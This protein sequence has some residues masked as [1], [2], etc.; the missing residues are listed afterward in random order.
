MGKFHL[1]KWYLDCT[2]DD[3]SALICYWAR[4]RWGA[5]ALTYA[6]TL[7]APAV[8][9]VRET[10]TLRSPSPPVLLGSECIWECKPFQVEGRWTAAAPPVRQEL[11]RTD[12]GGIRWSIHQ[13]LAH[14][15]IR[16]RNPGGEGEE[17]SGLG[18][19]EELELTIPPWRLPFNTLKWG[20]FLSPEHSLVW[21]DWEMRGP[22]SPH[23][24]SRRSLAV[25]DSTCSESLQIIDQAVRIPATAAELTLGTPRPLREGPLVATVFGAVP[26]LVGLL[27]E[28]FRQAHES[29]RLSP[30]ELRLP[31]QAREQGW[32][33]Y[34]VVTW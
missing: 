12:E 2:T 11:L 25:L 21:L 22:A 5:L 10:Q 8:G 9:E 3:G 34:E 31:G 16:F 7:H 28:K 17:V 33:I 18:Y 29:K 6:A 20:R 13:P 1:S 26:G 24:D 27:P 4:L 23:P 15:R 30:T 14:A 19:V 32:S